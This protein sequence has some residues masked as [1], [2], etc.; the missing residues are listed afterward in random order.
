[1]KRITILF[2]VLLALM[3][4]CDS[5]EDMYNV[6]G[7]QEVKK[8]VDQI[9]PLTDALIEETNKEAFSETDQTIE[10]IEEV[11]ET[12]YKFGENDAFPQAEMEAWQI[13]LGLA[14]GEW[15]ID[16]KELHTNL[17]DMKHALDTFIAAYQEMDDKNE[18]SKQALQDELDKVEA[19]RQHLGEQ[20]RK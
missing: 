9:I 2:V 12:Q 8:Y 6:E 4:A 3:V 18:P 17:E 15:A 13:E 16:G 14:E 5:D 7:F 20:M 19:A 1:M 11:N 10:Q